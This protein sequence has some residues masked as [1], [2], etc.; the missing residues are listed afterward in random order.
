MN[1]KDIG[2]PVLAFFHRWSGPRPGT[3]IAVHGEG[4][5]TV[6]VAVTLHPLETDMSGVENRVGPAGSAVFRG[7]VLPSFDD[8]NALLAQDQVLF[9]AMPTDARLAETEALLRQAMEDMRTA[10]RALDGAVDIN[11]P[12]EGV[13]EQLNVVQGVASELGVRV[14]NLE[15][16]VSDHKAMLRELRELRDVEPP[17]PPQIA[18]DVEQPSPAGQG[19]PEPQDASEATQEAHSGPSVMAPTTPGTP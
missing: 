6:D 11:I 1:N 7:L 15:V 19:T 4:D 18:Q 17:Q 10:K 5:S 2:R 13:R 16:A 9:A 3:I 14:K 8:G 12:I